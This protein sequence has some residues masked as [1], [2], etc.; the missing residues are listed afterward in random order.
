MPLLNSGAP[1]TAYIGT[2]SITAVQS[3]TPVYLGGTKTALVKVT[4]AIPT[5]GSL[6]F[7]SGVTSKSPKYT[8][9]NPTSP[10]LGKIT[11]K[12]SN[13]KVANVTG[14]VITFLKAGTTTITATQAAKG[15]YLAGTASALLTVGSP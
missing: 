2:T 5:L 14:N 6:S 12:S 9:T 3:A 15:N 8:I 4:A 13:T 11:Y 10:S 1:C 7:P